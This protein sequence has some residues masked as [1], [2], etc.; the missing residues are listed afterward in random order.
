MEP[1]GF[2]QDLLD[3]KILVLYVTARIDVPAT[4]QEIYEL[5]FQDDRLTY[6]DV[7]EA[8]PY[9]VQTGHLKEYPEKK[10]CGEKKYEITDKGRA[11]GEA[12]EDSIAYPVRERAKKAAQRF[13]RESKRRGLVHTE[14]LPADDGNYVARLLLNDPKGRLMT[15][16]LTA[17]NQPQAAAICRSFQKSGEVIYELLLSDL[18]EGEDFEE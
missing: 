6:F 4:V 14:I 10:G 12:T 1:L 8:I 11:N 3:V 15:L 17:P 2:I 5:C 9:L 18:L 7:C 16:E 13:N